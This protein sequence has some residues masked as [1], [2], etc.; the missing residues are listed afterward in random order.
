MMTPLCLRLRMQ[1]LLCVGAF[2]RGP[3]GHDPVEK[4][5]RTVRWL[6]VGVLVY[7]FSGVLLGLLLRADYFL[8]NV[9]FDL[10]FFV[11]G[12]F[13]MQQDP[14]F[15]PCHRSLSCPRRTPR[16][17]NH[18]LCPFTAWFG[19][20]FA[21]VI[22]GCWFM[23]NLQLVVSTMQPAYTNV[24]E[25]LTFIRLSIAEEHQ[26]HKELDDAEPVMQLLHYVVVA[27]NGE[28][29]GT[30]PEQ[31]ESDVRTEKKP[32][33]SG[34]V[35]G[36]E[37]AERLSSASAATLVRQEMQHTPVSQ[38]HDVDEVGEIVPQTAAAD[39]FL[40]PIESDPA[41]VAEENRNRKDAD[42]VRDDNTVGRTP[43]EHSSA[44][45]GQ[46]AHQNAA[47]TKT[48]TRW[49]AVYGYD[50]RLR[51]AHS[52]Q[53]L[54]RHR[55]SPGWLEA[56]LRTMNLAQREKLEQ[57]FED[58]QTALFCFIIYFVIRGLLQLLTGKY[59]WTLTSTE[60]QFG[61]RDFWL[62]PTDRRGGGP[63]N[64]EL[65]RGREGN[66][67]FTNARLLHDST[68]NSPIARMVSNAVGTGG[69]LQHPRL[70]QTNRILH[71]QGPAFTLEQDHEDSADDDDDDGGSEATFKGVGAHRAVEVASPST[72][73]VQQH[74]SPS[75]V[76]RPSYPPGQQTMREQVDARSGAE[77]MNAEDKNAIMSGT[78]GEAATVSSSCAGPQKECES[79]PA[80]QAQ[81]PSSPRR[82]CSEKGAQMMFLPIVD[83]QKKYAFTF[84]QKPIAEPEAGSIINPDGPPR[85]AF[86]PTTDLDLPPAEDPGL[87]VPQGGTKQ[88]TQLSHGT[89]MEPDLRDAWQLEKM[90]GDGPAE[91]VISTR[92]TELDQANGR[93]GTT[94]SPDIDDEEVQ[95]TNE[96]HAPTA[97]EV[98]ADVTDGGNAAVPV[99]A[100]P[101]DAM[102][103]AQMKANRDDAPV[104]DAGDDINSGEQQYQ[105]ER[106]SSALGAGGERF[107][108]LSRFLQ[109]PASIAS[110][111]ATQQS[112]H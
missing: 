79:D 95:G 56:Q 100:P 41:Q 59:S 64:V 7:A 67:F 97:K 107:R 60:L 29:Y 106:P 111:P 55:K 84:A 96:L 72:Y 103:N 57:H 42:G 1:C 101:E 104:V 63:M 20:F 89:K 112:P 2:V 109:T 91:E 73:L 66:R 14:F 45:Q 40:G 48:A 18:F 105:C 108:I 54:E 83:A 22:C 78:T 62:P 80:L 92:A 4:H 31:D 34:E 13:F 21:L 51:F 46:A 74:T 11:C 53:W 47:K 9:H 49:Q 58:Q 44:E 87:P 102:E 30:A 110:S 69:G 76:S 23:F 50:P 15:R 32:E 61:L 33:D 35:R 85:P 8:F 98:V 19:Y 12:I 65:E 77:I 81:R 16:E 68:T 99:A 17:L 5:R 28:D 93:F 52:A 82:S 71:F 75:M 37:T 24:S 39:K 38:S 94:R 43:G 86:V 3:A 36:A 6:L 25:G 10:F 90:E 26:K 88:D 27:D 70:P